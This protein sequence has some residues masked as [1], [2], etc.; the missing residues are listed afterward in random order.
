ML[1]FNVAFLTQVAPET[2][3]DDFVIR[4]LSPSDFDK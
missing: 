4:A 3:N 1:V 2:F